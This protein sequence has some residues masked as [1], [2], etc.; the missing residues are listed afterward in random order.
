VVSIKSCKCVLFHKFIN[1][2]YIATSSS[3]YLPGEEVSEMHELA[4]V[5]VFHVYNPPAVPTATDRPSINDHV[6]LRSYD[7]K[8]YNVLQSYGQQVTFGKTRHAYP[9][10]LI[11]LNFLIFIFIR[12]KGIETNIVIHQLFPNLVKNQSRSF[13]PMC[14][15]VP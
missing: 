8:G 13:N 3:A 6:V 5:R 4:V 12:V 11:Q 9:N 10:R 1:V 15:N 14:D 2:I 7:S